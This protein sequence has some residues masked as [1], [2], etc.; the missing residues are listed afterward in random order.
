[1]SS[2]STSASAT[3][4]RA[5]SSA[6]EEEYEDDTKGYIGYFMKGAKKT[7][8]F[9]RLVPEGLKPPVRWHPFAS[10]V[11][12]FVGCALLITFQSAMIDF[13]DN[14]LSSA[15]ATTTMTSGNPFL[16]RYF[17]WSPIQ[18]PFQVVRLVVFAYMFL[19]TIGLCYSLKGVWVLASYTLTSWNLL[20]ARFLLTYIANDA[21]TFPPSFFSLELVSSVRDF[22][23][24]AALVL[25]FPVLVMNSITVVV[26]WSLLVPVI[27][28]LLASDRYYICY[29]YL[30][31]RRE[32]QVFH[33]HTHTHTHTI[34]FTKEKANRLLAAQLVACS[35]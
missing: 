16:E 27:H 19:L 35:A 31:K 34:H 5:S 6:N 8:V 14:V 17:A 29:R 9:L 18:L 11:I 28:L 12:M 2:A 15:A 13:N 23:R 1:M 22:A 32:I 25:R 33:T 26:W 24:H 20:T 21:S 4:A 3:S 7:M 30:R 10:L